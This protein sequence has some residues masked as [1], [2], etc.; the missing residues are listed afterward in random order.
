MYTFY[1]RIPLLALLN[2]KAD[3][4]PE[5]HGGAIEKHGGATEKYWGATEKYWGATEKYCG[6]TECTEVLLNVLRCY[7]KAKHWG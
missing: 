2:S 4:I 7:R 5:K 3:E 6:A 1:P